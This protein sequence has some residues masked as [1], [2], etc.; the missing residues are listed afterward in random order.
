MSAAELHVLRGRMYEGKRNKARRGELF[1]LPR[2][3][4]IKLPTGEFAFDPDAQVQGVVRLVFDQFERL[5]TIRK[6]LRYLLA[7][8][9]RMGI[10]PHAGPNRGQ[11][12]WRV[13]RRDTVAGILSHPA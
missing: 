7:Q 9:I 8:G 13:P 6:V 3:G 2:T 5:G 1:T 11:L 4:Y 12:E 10:R